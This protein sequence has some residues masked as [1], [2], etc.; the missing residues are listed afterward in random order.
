M[1]VLRIKEKAWAPGLERGEIMI[2][3]S[4]ETKKDGLLLEHLCQNE[5]TSGSS[6]SFNLKHFHGLSLSFM[7]LS[8]L[9]NIVII[10]VPL[11]SF[12]PPPF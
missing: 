8:F 2:E 3:E 5:L 1:I 6:V 10:I 9:K 4:Y 11:F 7:T 12:H